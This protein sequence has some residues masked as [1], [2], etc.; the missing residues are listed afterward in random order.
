M[1][2][3]YVTTTSQAVL[4]DT[5]SA[6]HQLCK[7]TSLGF[8]DKKS[9]WGRHGAY[10]GPTGSRWAP[11]GPREPCYLGCFAMFGMNQ[12]RFMRPPVSILFDDSSCVLQV[13]MSSIIV[14]VK[15][16][17]SDLYVYLL[18]SPMHTIFITFIAEANVG[19][20]GSSHTIGCMAKQIAHV[21]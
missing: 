8:H 21:C 5:P 1:Q 12:I 7:H 10:L 19:L 13:N 2:S 11:C 15:N 9:S 17:Q 3:T 14:F 18:N 6:C 16:N 20:H 4:I